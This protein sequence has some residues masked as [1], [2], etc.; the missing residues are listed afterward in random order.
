MKAFGQW[1]SGG[2]HLVLTN[3]E[4]QMLSGDFGPAIAKA[5]EIQLAIGEAFGA[6]RMVEISRAHEAFYASESC[7]WFLELFAD[8][9]A[10]CRVPT[11]CNPIFDDSY[12][13]RIG[14]PIPKE[15]VIYAKRTREARKKMG[16][17][18]SECCTPYLQDNVPAKG[19]IIAFSESNATCYAN[20]IC[21]ARSHRES[22]NSALTAAITGRVPLYGLLL[23]K[24]RAGDTLIKIEAELRDDFDYHLL[25]YTLGKEVGAD[26]PIFTEMSSR[27][28]SREDLISLG[29]ELATSGTISMYHL[30]GLTP[31]APDVETALKG[32]APK[33]RMTVTESML[34]K[35]QTAMSYEAGKI[36]FVMFGCPHYTLNQIRDAARLLEGKKISKYVDFWILTSTATKRSAEHAGYLQ[37]I[38]KAG[39][40]IIS[41]TCSDQICWERL[42]RGKVGMTDSPKA[43]YY[44]FPR[45]I[46]FALRR[47]RECIEAALK[48]GW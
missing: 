40:H 14:K 26:I 4:K 20:S 3:H 18:P 29:A 12:F 42:Y 7:T 43:V 21:G 36:D 44:N 31:E 1:V 13:E 33:K 19:E 8:L 48:G 38:N 22:A 27:P 32:K 11:T 9:N 10:R 47:R 24:N 39:G 46:K 37:I 28:P 25:G 30:A 16:I 35:T 15:D 5:M 41:A 23:N 34:K 6:E 45:G 17:L 2:I